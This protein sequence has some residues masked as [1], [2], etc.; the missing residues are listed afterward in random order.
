MKILNRLFALGVL[1]SVLTPRVLLAQ[2]ELS[3]DA[4]D[5]D[6]KLDAD[7][8]LDVAERHTMVFSGDWNGGERVFNIRPRQTLQLISVERIDPATGAAQPLQSTIVVPN[9]VDEFVLS[10]G[11]TL[12]WRSRLPSDP[13]FSNTRLI[14]VLRYRLSGILL[15]DAEQYKID[16]D[17][18]FPDRVGDITR[19]SLNLSLD[20]VWQPLSEARERYTAG[21]I[22]PGRSFVLTIPLRYSGAGAPAF[23][24]TS[25]PPEVVQA[26]AAILGVFALGVGVFFVRESALGR[27][28]PLST[29]GIDATW[30]EQHIV[31]HPA[32]VV[33]AAWDGSIGAPEVVALIAR[34]T[35]EGKLASNARDSGS[36]TLRL[37][38]DREKLDGYER[39]LVDGLFFDGRT[40]TSTAAVQQH[41]KGKGFDPGQAIS[42]DLNTRVQAIL[43]PGEKRVSWIPTA[44]LFLAGAGLLA[45]TAYAATDEGLRAGPFV[46][47]FV[48]LFGG[49]LL[50]IPG[51]LFRARMDR[52]VTAAAVSMIPA[53][54]VS[55]A[56]AAFL[57]IIVGSGR[58]EL[59]WTL[60]GGIAAWVICIS[61]A[62]ITA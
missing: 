42:P 30:I 33:G 8:V 21:P 34:M 4:L 39:A 18:A 25:R 1:L 17:F 54:L 50:Q 24:D 45:W 46:M 55:A 43:P 35:G 3:W 27:F 57:W 44:A 5:V 49:I 52:G 16:H 47:V 53:L 41:Y 26:V 23:L 61:N 28:A 51:W 14:Y 7:G 37:L 56:A 6:A 40:E 13:P 48:L 62:S 10:D 22:K 58:L 36:M 9:N 59:P 15:K 60:V 2:R 11:R 32:E 19:F 12:R 31:A 29:S 38:V 20:P